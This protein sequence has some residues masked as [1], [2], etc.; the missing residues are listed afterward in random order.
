MNS[1]VPEGNLA[2]KYQKSEDASVGLILG[3]RLGQ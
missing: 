2:L 3:Y 1:M